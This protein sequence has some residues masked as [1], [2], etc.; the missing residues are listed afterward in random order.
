MCPSFTDINCAKP[1]H[2]LRNPS[3]SK[4]PTQ[5]ARWAFSIAEVGKKS[6]TAQEGRAMGQNLFRRC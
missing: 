1:Q 5:I 2:G 4:K 3:L 6:P